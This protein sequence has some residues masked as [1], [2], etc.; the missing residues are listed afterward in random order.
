MKDIL[1]T[2]LVGICLC[3]L[4]SCQTPN[5]EILSE[6]IQLSPTTIP[7]ALPTISPTPTPEPPR[8]LTICSQEP[9]SL[10]LFRDSSSAARTVLQAIY[11]GPVDVENF[12]V[13]PII[14][15][16]IP[17]LENGELTLHTVDVHPGEL[18]IDA[19][20]KWV[21]L[22]DGITYRPS[23]CSESSCA[24]TYEG[25]G[26]VQMDSMVADFKLLP[27]TLWSDG[28]RLTAADSVFAF[29]LYEAMFGKTP[30]EI[31]QVTRAYA[32]LDDQTVRWTG[33]PG[34]LG[35]VST[36]YFS[37]LP[38]HLWGGF[39]FDA[40]ISSETFNR[41][42]I[43]WGPY[44]IEEW[45][46][47][48]HITLS[49]N[50]NYFRSTEGLPH[51]D[52]L[53]YR[54]M[55]DGDEAIDALLIGECDLVDRSLLQDERLPRL[56]AEQETGKIALTFHLGS[57]WELAAFGINTLKQDGLEFFNQVEVRQAVA[58]CID[59]QKI[60]DD[61]LFG[62]PALMHTYVPP[63]HP[64]YNPDVREYDYDPEGAAS[65]LDSAGWVDL[66]GD[67][68]TSRTSLGVPGIPDS[69]PL[70][71]TY[72]VPVGGERPEVAE[73]IQMG[74][75]ACGIKVDLVV[76]EWDVLM[77]PGPEG[78]LFGRQFDMAQ[79][80]WETALEPSCNLFASD[81]IPGPYPEFP[82]GWGGA[83]LSG[84]SN[85]EFDG[86]CSEAFFSLPGSDLF[87]KSH[88][89]AQAIFADELPV[90]PLYQHI[91]MVAARPDMCDPVVSP[92][93]SNTLNHLEL[94]DYGPSCRSE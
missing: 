62:V 12:T 5:P 34:Y 67:P 6:T 7:E 58:M 89:L 17:S 93:T 18:I 83:N 11:D 73:F 47:G 77:Q 88:F 78:L 9:T 80:A 16:R 74:M 31:L 30:P 32:A 1:I 22:G 44:R 64:L 75:A 94:F 20:G 38:A 25:S 72:M 13:I 86:A 27:N 48:D 37:P 24:L 71:F 21:S 51:F 43:G 33:I 3:T 84:Y 81:E 85:H 54:F 59:R 19:S 52:Y 79:F 35:K 66:D 28:V 29:Q 39:D 76:E 91:R 26:P 61:L 92:A 87:I 57:A 65:I 41:E 55:N 49:R 14:L 69:T 46:A 82:R 23:G 63:N 36:K 70:S 56:L 68:Q 4:T 42:P 40:L 90:I 53:V 45:I 8:V 50:P 15:E 10:F 2:L 60:L